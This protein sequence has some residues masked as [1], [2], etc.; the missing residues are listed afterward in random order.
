MEIM[1]MAKGEET[2]DNGA[3]KDDNM[4]YNDIDILLNK[5]NNFPNIHHNSK[6]YQESF[7]LHVGS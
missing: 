1:V 4:N 5:S 2:Y 7:L 6:N 3:N